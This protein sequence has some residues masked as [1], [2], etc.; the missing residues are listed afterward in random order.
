M[1]KTNINKIN[2][3]RQAEISLV[4][5]LAVAT[6]V[7]VPAPA[8]AQEQDGEPKKVSHAVRH[9]REETGPHYMSY[10]ASQRTPAR[11]GLF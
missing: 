2:F 10:G 1:L 8:L 9:E 3:L 11:T 4:A 7:Y 6:S 5:S